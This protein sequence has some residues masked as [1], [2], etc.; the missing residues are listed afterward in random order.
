VSFAEKLSRAAARNGSRLCIGLDPE[1]ARLPVADA[2]VFLRS[3]IEA[4]ADLVC[5]YKPNLAFF[6]GLGR[7]GFDVLAQVL[8]A[9]PDGIR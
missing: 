2:A 4:T 3:V 5:C 9:I 7:D 1:P 8:A 6:E